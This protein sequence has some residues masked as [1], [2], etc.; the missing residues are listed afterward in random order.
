MTA[1]NC[2]NTPAAIAAALAR[3]IAL[4]AAELSKGNILPSL[5]P[6][7]GP[8]LQSLISGP[9]QAAGANSLS[10]LFDTYLPAAVSGAAR[11]QAALTAA[12]GLPPG[13]SA[14]DPTGLG[15]AGGW[16]AIPPSGPAGSGRGG[17]PWPTVAA[18]AGGSGLTANPGL[19]PSFVGAAGT[20]SFFDASRV[21]P[22]GAAAPGA[23]VQ[24]RVPS[25]S[26]G[27]PGTGTAAAGVA[28]G[29]AA[30]G[31]LTPGEVSAY[32]NPGLAP[33]DDETFVIAEWI[34][35]G[36]N[37]LLLTE[38]LGYAKLLY[39]GV[40]RPCAR[41]YKALIYGNPDYPVRLGQI[42]FGIVS[43]QVVRAELRAGPSSRHLLGQA[44]NFSIK[45]VD[46]R[47]VCDDIEAGSIQVTVGTY[48]EVNGIHASLPFTTGGI[49]ISGLRLFS[50]LGSLGFIGY[51]FNKGGTA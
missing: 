33:A 21:P 4:V 43:A 3:V 5:A 51:A 34:G 6:L 27:A 23:A 26:P 2:Q 18:A 15:A 42:L 20:G 19:R 35:P 16:P 12:A 31:S 49:Q 13:G 44:V 47:R 25:A 29:G 22:G 1:T 45:G 37:P 10:S 14:T 28:S 32:F 17:I 9:L 46:N 50:S 39:Y 7:V 40:V 41:Y 36:Q 48:G 30:Q 38:Q 24:A 8:L 11:Q